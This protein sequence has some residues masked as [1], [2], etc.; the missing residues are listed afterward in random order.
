[1]NCMFCRSI[2][3]LSCAMMLFSCDRRSESGGL[4]ILQTGCL[5]GNL[6]PVSLSHAVPRQ[7][8]QYISAYVNSVRAEAAKTGA[9]VVLIDSGNSLSGS[10]ASELLDS[11]N[12]ITFFN[13]VGYDAIILGN[14]DIQLSMKSLSEVQAPILNPFRWELPNYSRTVRTNSIVLKKGRLEIRLFAV[15]C[16]DQSSTWPLTPAGIPPGVEAAG[17]PVIDQTG[18]TGH[19]LNV[20]VALNADFFRRP[21]LVNTLA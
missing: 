11:A 20:C 4:I 7:S 5:H 13:K 9:V 2:T 6:Y 21:E 10:F 15:F 14:Q 1:M 17:L 8:Y 16:P 3:L 18:Q 12:V 19:T